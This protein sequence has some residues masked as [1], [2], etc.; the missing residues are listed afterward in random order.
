MSVELKL[1]HYS[2]LSRRAK[3]LIEIDLSVTPTQGSRHVVIDSTGVKV[4]G[5]GAWKTRNHGISK[6]RAWLKLHVG[7]DEETGEILAAVVTP[8]STGTVNYWENCWVRL[9]TMK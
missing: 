5:E 7:L 4:Y 2:T 8:N 6:R 3:R 1:L 9:T